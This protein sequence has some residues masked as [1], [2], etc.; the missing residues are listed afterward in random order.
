MKKF[1]EKLVSSVVAVTAATCMLTTFAPA[2]HAAAL[3]DRADT[4][5]QKIGISTMYTDD[6]GNT[7][8]L[9]VDGVAESHAA[10][11]TVQLSAAFY[12]VGSKAYRFSHWSG[13]TYLLADSTN[14]DISFVMP[15]ASVTLNK[16]FVIVG[17][18]N[19]DGDVNAIDLNLLRRM[20]DGIMLP[21]LAADI[22]NDGRWDDDDVY[23]M[24]RMLQGL[25]SPTE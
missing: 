13:D 15:Q 8:T 21:K 20:V 6:S 14:P 12:K 19:G 2:S 5:R 25:Y 16:N 1:T 3:T 24:R 7:Y 10:G 4:A 17:D 18:V 11:D 22:N 9:T 23:L